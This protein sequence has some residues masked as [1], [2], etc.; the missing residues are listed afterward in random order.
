VLIDWFTVAAQVVNFV[1]LV[2]LMKRFLYQ[3]VLD[4]IAA[5]EQRIASTVAQAASTQ[6]QADALQAQLQQKIQAFEAAQGERARAAKRALSAELA[7]IRSH[8]QEE[9]NATQRTRSE[10]LA[11]EAKRLQTTITQRTQQQVLEIT[12]RVLGDLADADVEALV[13]KRFECWLHDVSPQQ[14]EVWASAFAGV[15][16]AAPALVRSAF[17]WDPQHRAALSAAIDQ[18]L[19]CSVPLAFETKPE[20]TLGVELSGQGQKLAWS[21][22]DYLGALSRAI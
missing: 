16:E 2:A 18:A 9:V 4:A 8:A 21:V 12:R 20:L 17:T 6:R 10:A 1:I 13:V 11:Q 7:S 19:G 3:P 22:D 14:R 15:S 5:C